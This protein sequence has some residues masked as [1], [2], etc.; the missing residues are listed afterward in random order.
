LEPSRYDGACS[1]LT[2]ILVHSKPIVVGKLIRELLSVRT[3]ADEWA[4]FSFLHCLY[5]VRS[6]ESETSSYTVHHMS[7]SGQNPHFPPIAQWWG[8]YLVGTLERFSH[9]F[10]CFITEHS[11]SSR[12]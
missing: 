1:C 6:R 11:V 5:G 8:N 7:P 2:Q 9:F 4:V 10:P 12:R 3:V